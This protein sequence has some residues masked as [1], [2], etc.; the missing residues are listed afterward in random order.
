MIVF[1]LT[2]RDGADPVLLLEEPLNL[3]LLRPFS[4]PARKKRRQRQFDDLLDLFDGGPFAR[5][6][7]DLRVHLDSATRARSFGL[8]T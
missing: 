3:V 1:I 8:T 6:Q 4:R 5:R 2:F 7:D